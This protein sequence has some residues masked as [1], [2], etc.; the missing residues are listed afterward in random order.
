MRWDLDLSIHS[1]FSKQVTTM[2]ASGRHFV[3]FTSLVIVAAVLSTLSTRN[4]RLALLRLKQQASSIAVKDDGRNDD[5]VGS[6]YDLS[7][8]LQDRQWCPFAKCQNSPLCKPC[9]RR[10]LLILATGR[11]GSTSMLQMLN[12]LPGVRLSG[13]NNNAVYVV[14]SAF[15]AIFRRPFKVQQQDGAW[16][17]YRIRKSDMACTAQSIFEAI[18]PPEEA[19]QLSKMLLE[20]DSH[21]IVGFKTMRIHEKW[22]AEEAVQIIQLL[23]PC[24]R[25]VVNYNSNTTKQA[26]SWKSLIE[27]NKTVQVI[28]TNLAYKNLKLKAIAEDIGPEQAFVMD[29]GVLNFPGVSC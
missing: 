27:K 2:T 8:N 1:P 12:L 23:F 24:S 14:A 20:Q 5:A 4:G 9:R 29:T 13:E 3:L 18:N 22:S 15:D 21:T 7:T 26:M 28:S 10:W 17:H 19:V 11:Y 25:I 16:G 6:N